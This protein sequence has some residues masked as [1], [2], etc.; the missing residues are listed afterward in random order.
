MKR[1]ISFIVTA[2][3][4]MSIPFGMSACKKKGDDKIVIYVDG[5]GGNGNFNTTI[6]MDKTPENPYPYNT[7]E[8]LAGEYM[9]AHPDVTIIINNQSLN[10]D[11]EAITSLFAAE[12]A[13]HLLF[14]QSPDPLTD[15]KNGYIVD[16]SE[17]IEQP[18][19]YCAEGTLGSA[20]WK[21][22][23]NEKEFLATTRMTDGKCYSICL[24]KIPIGILYNKD[25]FEAAGL[26]DEEGNIV[27]PDT[28]G[29][30]LEYQEI[31]S[32]KLDK[33]PYFPIYTWYDIVLEVSVFADL[34]EQ[35][36]SIDK[37]G[38]IS[39]EELVKA[40]NNG[41]WG[42]SSTPET[43]AEKRY[44]E[45]VKLLKK[46]TEYYPNAWSS[47]DALEEFLKGNVAMIEATGGY[48]AQAAGD[49]T[50]DFEVGVFGFPTLSAEDSVYGGKGVYRG[51]AGLTTGYFVTNTAVADGQKTVDACVD[52]LKFLTA[53]QNN[54]RL[55]NDLGLGL[56]LDANAEINPL[57]QPLIDIY[58]QDCQDPNRY[59]WNTF[60]SW[61]SFNKLYY[62]TFLITIQG[63]QSGK[64]DIDETLDMISRATKT[65]IE[66]AMNDNGWTKDSWN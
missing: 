52:F 14:M 21:D 32:T 44:R 1:I 23:Y 59:D 31:I 57:F 10:S 49:M 60:N 8:K 15:A 38:F 63:Y 61:N 22:I 9:A 12:E 40:Y 11:R 25:M 18:N 48:M 34:F 27:T 46:K 42:I 65:A 3:F 33:N 13:P 56:P 50:K 51:S 37:N 66:K 47:Y 17:Y 5:G 55:I 36:D 62:D 64:Y 58:K 26:V 2:I 30:L 19:Q 39:L 54:N 29:E 4:V 7:L 43:E 35:Y 20:K 28:F 24:E 41:T 6:S 16:L 53:P 45:Y